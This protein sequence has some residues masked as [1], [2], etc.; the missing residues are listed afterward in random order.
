M[1]LLYILGYY[2]TACVYFSFRW[3]PFVHS[4]GIV[5]WNSTRRDH[6]G[7]PG[8]VSWSGPVSHVLKTRF[9]Y[10]IMKSCFENTILV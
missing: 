1:N 10:K 7:N 9:Q 2:S 3:G 4:L 6:P 8:G 5:Q